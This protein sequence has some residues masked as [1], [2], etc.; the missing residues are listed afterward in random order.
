MKNLHICLVTQEYPPETNWGGIATYSKDLAEALAQKGHKVSV[1]A[2]SSGDQESVKVNNGVNVHRI[3]PSWARF[4]SL[5]GFRHVY[6]IFDGY[7]FRVKAKLMAIHRQEPIDLIETPNLHGEVLFFQ[8]ACPEVPVVVRL[9]SSFKE[10]L[11][12]SRQPYTLAKRLDHF[13]ERQALKRATAISAV[14]KAIINYNQ[15]ILPANPK[16]TIIQNFIN[17]EEFLADTTQKEPHT[18]LYAGRLTLRKGVHVLAEALQKTLANHPKVRIVWAGADGVSPTG[19]SMKAW[20]KEKVGTQSNRLTFLGPIT[21]D[22]LIGWY[23]KAG[24]VVFPTLFEPFGLIALEA[25]AAKCLVIASDIDGPAEIIQHGKTG[26]L[27]EA[28]NSE[29]LHKALT[30]VL[31]ADFPSERICQQAYQELQ[32]KYSKPVVIDVIE[33]YYQSLV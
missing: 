12:F 33:K 4:Y 31:K 7:H 1:V 20:I 26:W 2:R 19:G 22:S 29:A 3:M 27:F 8:R 6:K 15:T 24:I 9:H 17:L 10:N 25:M 21:R 5:P 14:S 32:E 30:E 16:P 18:I 23:Q 13:L 28:G 11:K